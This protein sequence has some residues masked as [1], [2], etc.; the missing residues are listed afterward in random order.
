MLLLCMKNQ[1]VSVDR[2]QKQT[3]Q[4]FCLCGLDSFLETTFIMFYFSFRLDPVL[5]KSRRP[6]FVSI[7]CIL[8]EQ[9]TLKKR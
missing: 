2:L 8:F 1:Y 9:L 4:I 6:H 7:E 5:Q 3:K